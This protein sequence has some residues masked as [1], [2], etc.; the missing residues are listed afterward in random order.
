[1]DEALYLISRDVEDDDESGDDDDDLFK[2]CSP[3]DFD[4]ESNYVLVGPEFASLFLSVRPCP[5]QEEGLLRKRR[6][7]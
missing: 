3:E 5:L 6:Y 2:L 1:M 4:D 7:L